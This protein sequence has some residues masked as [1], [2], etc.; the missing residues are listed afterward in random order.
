MRYDEGGIFG[1]ITY[2]LHQPRNMVAETVS[3][4]CMYVLHRREF[5]AMAKELPSL[6]LALQTA[7]LKSIC[8]SMSISHDMSAN[9]TK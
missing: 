5:Q 4:G 2:M 8:L 3:P 7:L 9:N 1:Q 6:A